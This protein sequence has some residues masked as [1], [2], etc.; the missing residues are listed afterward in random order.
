MNQ[1]TYTR[2]FLKNAEMGVTDE[3]VSVYLRKWFMNT[4]KKEEGGLRLTDDGFDFVKDILELKLYEV[5]FPATLDLKPQVILF[6][7]KFIDCPYYLTPESIT[8]LSERKNFELHLFAGD[9]RQFGLIKAMKRKN[10]EENS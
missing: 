8:V 3:N 1:S 6:L 5:P 9:V 7:D 2:V 10:K 4:R